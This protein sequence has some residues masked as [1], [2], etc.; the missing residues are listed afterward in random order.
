MKV[1]NAYSINWLAFIWEKNSRFSF[2]VVDTDN[3][4][5]QDS[6]EFSKV[7]ERIDKRYDKSNYVSDD[8]TNNGKEKHTPKS[9]KSKKAKKRSRS[10]STSSSSSSSSKSSSSIESSSS[11]SDRSRSKADSSGNSQVK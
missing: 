8:K 2:H 6:Q 4:R 10:S 1:T 5:Q 7:E 11:S 9:L 3:Q